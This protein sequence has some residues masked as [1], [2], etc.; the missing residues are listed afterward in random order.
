MVVRD[1]LSQRERLNRADYTIERIVKH[2]DPGL[3]YEQRDIGDDTTASNYDLIE[4]ALKELGTINQSTRDGILKRDT[5]NAYKEGVIA[6]EDHLFDQLGLAAHIYNHRPNNETGEHV[7]ALATLYHNFIKRHE[8]ITEYDEADI[9]YVL[10]E[11]HQTANRG[12]SNEDKLELTQHV[13]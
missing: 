4:A 7:A 2:S 6:V 11:T 3:I 9:T 10:D 12:L 1:E 13:A 8:Q 5:Y